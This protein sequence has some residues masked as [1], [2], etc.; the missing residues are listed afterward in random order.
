MTIAK[1]D[2]CLDSLQLR[3]TWFGFVQIN[4]RQHRVRCGPDTKIVLQVEHVG[5]FPNMSGIFRIQPGRVI[6][7]PKSE[8]T[9]SDRVCCLEEWK[10]RNGAAR[11]FSRT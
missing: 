9:Q 10:D 4:R 11:Y 8:I 6:G 2:D 7:G 3:H 5:D 1:R